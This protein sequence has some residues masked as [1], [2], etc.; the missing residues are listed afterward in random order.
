MSR[1]SKNTSF[2]ALNQPAIAFGVALVGLWEA[3]ARGLSLSQH[4]FPPPSLVIWSL[5]CRGR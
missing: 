5:S 3:L 4:V 1:A 2:G